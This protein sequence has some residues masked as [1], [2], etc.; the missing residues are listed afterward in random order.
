MPVAVRPLALLVSLALLLVACGGADAQGDEGGNGRETLPRV[1][2]WDEV[3]EEAEGQRVR[4]WMFGGD[5]RINRYVD[6]HVVPAAE[7]LGV[8]LQRVPI[9]DTA[10]AV[11]RVLAERQAGVDEDGAVDLIWINGENFAAGK[12]AGLWLDGW[13]DEL[14][15]AALVDPETVELDFGVEVEGQESPWSRAAFVIGYDEERTPRPPRT[16]EDLLS[17]AREHP[18]RVTY[19]AP[20]DFTGAAFVRRAVME[21]GEDEAFELLSE[22]RPLQW[23]EGSTFP[24]DEAELNTL[25]GDGEVDLTFSYDPN[26]VQTGVRTGQLP[27]SARPATFATGTLQNVSYVTIPANAGHVAGALVVADLL[28]E[29]ELQA[30]KADPDVLGVPSVLD[31]DRLDGDDRARLDRA[32]E[33][34]YLLDDLGELLDELPASRVDELNDRWR[35]EVLGE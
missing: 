21:L 34:P 10:D 17:Y 30:A 35:R 16:F 22:L 32:T 18:G 33:G 12:E 7:D 20:P 8:E 13:A 31:P 4:W 24:G 19:P 14:P 25:F 1:E 26:V 23:R 3:L 11:Q 15:N 27:E 6:E 9:D 28:L 29:P 2:Q 5:E